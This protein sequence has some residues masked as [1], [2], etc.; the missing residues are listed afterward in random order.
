MSLPLSYNISF[1]NFN[2]KASKDKSLV[3]PDQD[4]DKVVFQV[5]RFEI[6]H[7][8]WPQKAT[9]CQVDDVIEND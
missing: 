8:F 2:P 9:H 3:I 6:E 7:N 4:V 5:D 1:L